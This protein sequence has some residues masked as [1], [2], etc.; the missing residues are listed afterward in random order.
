MLNINQIK[1]ELLKSYKDPRSDFRIS[2]KDY[3]NILIF[4]NN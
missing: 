3:W 4:N 2:L 1:L